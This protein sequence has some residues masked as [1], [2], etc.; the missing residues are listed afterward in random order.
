[1]SRRDDFMNAHYDSALF[2][3]VNERDWYHGTSG[4]HD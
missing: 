2:D 4:F 3:E 1:M